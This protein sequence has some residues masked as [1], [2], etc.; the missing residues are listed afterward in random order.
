MKLL[1]TL[2]FLCFGF[3]SF[4]QEVVF[5]GVTYYVDR[6]SIFKNDVDVTNSLTD[7]DIR[8]VK[9]V[10]DTEKLKAKESKKQEIQLKKSV[11][12]QRRAEKKQ[13]KAEK[14]LKRKE[15]AQSNFDK[16]S[17]KY[18]RAVAKYDS[19]KKRG[20]LSPVKESKW[21]EKVEKLRY[22]RDKYKN[23]LKRT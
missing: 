7:D 6:E 1:I 14:T 4:S 10:L 19:L 21:M 16:S 2:I 20:R 18:D 8:G 15:K 23:K 11:K 3:T 13:K 12:S 5:N 22:K 17:N 9:N